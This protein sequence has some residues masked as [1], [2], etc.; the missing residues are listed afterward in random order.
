MYSFCISLLNHQ[1][2]HTSH[3]EQDTQVVQ[4]PL[5]SEHGRAHRERPVAH[6]LGA[7]A[8]VP[9][10]RRLSARR[11]S[12][13][14]AVQDVAGGELAA[15]GQ[16]ALQ[17]L[18]ASSALRRLVVCAH[19]CGLAQR[20]VVARR[21]GHHCRV[22]RRS[23]PRR[24]AVVAKWQS[25]LLLVVHQPGRVP[26]R[27]GTS[28]DARRAGRVQADRGRLR[29]HC[30]ASVVR[31]GHLDRGALVKWQ[32]RLALITFIFMFSFTALY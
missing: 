29:R 6:R 12:L 32:S 20:G 10:A 19:A 24:F 9:R 4:V 30:P 18:L 21:S 1:N 17:R 5:V 25:H 2:M 3:H 27:R 14:E 13:G 16:C 15:S 31:V 11:R 8:G 7:G 23:S 22:R 28:T 26:Q